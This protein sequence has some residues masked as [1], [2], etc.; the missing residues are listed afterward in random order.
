MSAPAPIS[1]FSL[2]TKSGV[3][4]AGIPAG[5]STRLDAAFLASTLLL[6]CLGLLLPIATLHVLDRIVPAAAY[7]TLLF[8]TAGLAAATLAELTLRLL[9]A[10]VG[11][12]ASALYASGLRQRAL[13]FRL[14]AG[15]GAAPTSVQ[16]ERLATID[17]FAAFYAGGARAALID[18]PFALLALGL[19]LT[20][21]G[22]IVLAPISVIL[23]HF[24][25]LSG[26]SRRLRERLRVRHDEAVKAND[27]LSEVFRAALTV[28]CWALER[29]ILR[30]YE[31]LLSAATDNHREALLIN[32]AV[33]RQS[34]LF[35][36]LVTVATLS[37]GGAMAILGSVSIGVVAATTLL[38][39]RAAQP[40]LRA[41]KAWADVQRAVIAAEEVRKL[42]QTEG[43]APAS[44]RSA[45]HAETGAAPSIALPGADQPVSSGAAIE[46]TGEDAEARTRALEM[47]TGLRNAPEGSPWE[48]L[49]LSGLAPGAYRASEDGSVAFVSR[50]PR[51][52]NGSILENITLFGRGASDAAAIAAA[53][54]LG[55][56]EDVHNL[57]RGFDT[58]IGVSSRDALSPASLTKLA[59]ARAV[60]WGARLI[61]LDNPT[62]HLSA[63]DI[64]LLCDELARLKGARTLVMASGEPAL[65]AL[66]DRRFD[67]APQGEDLRLKELS[68]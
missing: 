8:I 53:T 30:R 37:L 42:F 64:A 14:T 40:A 55:L 31:R 44:V 11:A 9:Q 34:N 6:N 1:A 52:L 24:F 29:L 36:N 17:Q 54:R 63:H 33:Q 23:L 51:P 20:L 65:R 18:L 12:M 60:A 67:V 25:L 47:I 4:R 46:L 43:A 48:T 19:I 15:E 35:A 38:A 61:A 57:P 10:R 22:W 7:E 62:A 21:G 45:A 5:E 2:L 59:L 28:K 27:F 66:C 58:L 16:L 50:S 41:A 26:L 49:R 3:T 68:S 13:A 39:G 56:S 32:G